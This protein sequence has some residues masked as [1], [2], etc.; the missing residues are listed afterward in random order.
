MDQADILLL[1]TRFL[2][3]YCLFPENTLYS[4]EKCNLEYISLLVRND[5]SKISF[6]LGVTVEGTFHGYS[7]DVYVMELLELG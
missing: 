7:M 1:W 2:D 4:L 6:V 5:Q 3:G